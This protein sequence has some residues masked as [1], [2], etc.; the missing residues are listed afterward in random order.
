MAGRVRCPFTSGPW[1]PRRATMRGRCFRENDSLEPRDV[2][3]AIRRAYRR[4]R[5][6][7]KHVDRTFLAAGRS[8]IARDFVAGP[9]SYV[10]PGCSISPGVSIGAY[11]ML[12]PGVKVLGNDHVF[13]QPGT[14]IIFSGRPR[15]KAT[16]IG[17]DV[18]IGADAVVICGVEIGNGAMVGAGAVV[19]RDVP[20]YCVVAGV[21]AGI[22]RRRFA[23]ADR[24]SKRMSGVAARPSRGGEVPR[25]AASGRV[26]W[27]PAPCRCSRS[28]ASR[29]GCVRQLSPDR[30]T[31]GSG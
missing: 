27:R 5:L 21:P 16:R 28:E 13:D 11:T 10:G 24:T 6:R 20:A 19:T 1:K 4:Q 15:R 31:P 22:T 25:G 9:S 14:P 12:G 17:C 29:E 18:W 23:S 2:V 8:E 30:R 7:L 3:R 26:G